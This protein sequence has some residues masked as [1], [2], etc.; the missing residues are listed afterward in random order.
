MLLCKDFHL[1]WD[2]WSVKQNFTID[3]RPDH[4]TVTT[5]PPPVR[6]EKFV[7]KET[8][9]F[10]LRHITTGFLICCFDVLRVPQSQTWWMVFIDNEIIHGYMECDKHPKNTN[11]SRDLR[12]H[13]HGT[14]GSK[15]W[16]ELWCKSILGMESGCFVFRTFVGDTLTSNEFLSGPLID[17][18]V[19]SIQLM[20]QV[21]CVVLVWQHHR[22]IGRNSRRRP[23]SPPEKKKFPPSTD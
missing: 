5:P 8:Q 10:V 6:L 23:V 18:L 20:L 2:V 9:S 4:V 12:G 21:T 16:F 19:E 15:R 14:T 1:K 22:L 7:E 11:S 13:L 17:G 3:D